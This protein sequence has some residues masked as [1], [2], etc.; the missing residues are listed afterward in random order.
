MG[1]MANPGSMTAKQCHARAKAC[2]AKAGLATNEPVALEF[3]KIAAQWRAM[4]ERL[5]FL[6]S[7]EA[8]QDAAVGAGAK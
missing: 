5:T 2:A 7:I 4:A 3:F 8:P 6:G 1:S